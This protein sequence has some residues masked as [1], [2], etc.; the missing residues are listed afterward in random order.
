MV[1]A[2]YPSGIPVLPAMPPQTE[3]MSNGLGWLLYASALGGGHQGYHGTMAAAMV[4][5]R[6]WRLFCWCFVHS[7][8]KGVI[9]VVAENK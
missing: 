4:E 5:R 9:V 7:F 6:I 1:S 2:D 8:N 3:M